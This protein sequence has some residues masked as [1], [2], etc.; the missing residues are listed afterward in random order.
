MKLYIN[1]KQL[2]WGGKY[3]VR[4]EDGNLKY[5]VKGKPLTLSRSF[6]VLDAEDCEIAVVKQKMWCVFPKYS[7]FYNGK[8]IAEIKRVGSYFKPRYIVER[9]NWLV[10]GDF[11]GHRYTISCG[12]WVVAEIRKAWMSWGDNYE[13]DIKEQKD[14]IVALVTVVV[15]DCVTA[16]SSN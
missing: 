14:E 12:D 2:S 4:D 10:E 3:Y 16:S 11:G 7:V 8:S 13:L 9:R 6:S 5:N 1:Q 15:I